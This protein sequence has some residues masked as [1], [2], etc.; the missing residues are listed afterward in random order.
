MIR[1]IVATFILAVIAVHVAAGE[2]DLETQMKDLQKERL[3]TLTKLVEIYTLRYEAGCVSGEEFADAENALVN[4][5]L[6]PVLA[7]VQLVANREKPD[8]VMTIVVNA[9]RKSL[10]VTKTTFHKET[11]TFVETYTDSLFWNLPSSYMELRLV[12]AEKDEAE[13]KKQQKELVKVLTRLVEN[14]EERYKTGTLPLE[15]LLKAQAALLDAQMDAAEKPEERVAL[16]EE[17]GK[18]ETKLFKVADSRRKAAAYSARSHFLNTKIRML[19]ESSEKDDVAEQIKAAQ[20]ERIEALTELVKI[21]KELW[22]TNWTELATITQAKAELANAQADAA[23]TFEAKV[24]V[25]TEAVK[26]Q[27]GFVQVIERREQV[28]VDSYDK[29]YRERLHLLDL[30]IRLLRERSAQKA[31]R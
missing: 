28:G 6:D 8:S 31:D 14:C 22:E 1:S 2:D 24:L 19:Q 12:R 10:D 11:G 3:E 16:L 30:K 7:T 25:L 5:Q 17:H 4:A 27:A 20:K 26:E 9:H 29:V 23:G 18:N 21:N 13:I 15:T